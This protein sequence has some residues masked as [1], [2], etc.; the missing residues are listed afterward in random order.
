MPAWVAAPPPVFREISFDFCALFIDKIDLFSERIHPSENIS[1]PQ[2][3]VIIRVGDCCGFARAR[4]H[5]EHAKP[6]QIRF[7][8]IN[9]NS[10]MT[11]SMINRF[12]LRVVVRNK[13]SSVYSWHV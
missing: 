5:K 8:E 3:S 11:A 10:Q 1:L 4:A 13:L 9:R 7:I 12:D 6:M 2:S